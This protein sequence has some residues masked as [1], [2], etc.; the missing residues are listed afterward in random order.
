M[1]GTHTYAA[2]GT[3]TTRTTLAEP[4]GHATAALGTAVVSPEAISATGVDLSAVAG[5]GLGTS[6]VGTDAVVATFSDAAPGLSPGAF[7]ATIDW[8]DG[9]AP[10]E[11]RIAAD[12]Q[13]PGALEGPAYSPGM[14]VHGDHIHAQATPG[15][16]RL[17]RGRKAE[18]G[19]TAR[20]LAGGRHAIPL[21]APF[22]NRVRPRHA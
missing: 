13:S 9:S 18:P 19:A 21:Q 22:V 16:G 17:K 12:L 2:A 7:V 20:K 10:T 15:Q 1:A 8:G 6:G 5:S 11:G 14:A 3:Y 4:S